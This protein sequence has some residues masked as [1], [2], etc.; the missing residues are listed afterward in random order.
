MSI[1]WCRDAEGQE[2]CLILNRS[3]AVTLKGRRSSPDSVTRVTGW[4]R[5]SKDSG[6]NLYVNKTLPWIRIVPISFPYH[7]VGFENVC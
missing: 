6:E 2:V 3:Y 5:T 4:G 7:V 1:S